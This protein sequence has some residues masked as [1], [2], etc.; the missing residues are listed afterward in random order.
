LGIIRHTFNSTV[1]CVI[2]GKSNFLVNFCDEVFHS[3]LHVFLVG[4]MSVCSM[5]L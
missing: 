2:C 4:V 1:N 3:L 5:H